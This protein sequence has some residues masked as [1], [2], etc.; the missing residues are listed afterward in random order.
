MITPDDRESTTTSSFCAKSE[1]LFGQQRRDFYNRIGNFGVVEL[2]DWTMYD[3][4]GYF[5]SQCGNF[6]IN[7]AEKSDGKFTYIKHKQLK[8]VCNIMRYF[9]ECN[10]SIKFDAFYPVPKEV[11]RQIIKDYFDSEINRLKYA[12]DTIKSVELMKHSKKDIIEFIN[13]YT[14]APTPDE[15]GFVMCEE[16]ETQNSRLEQQM[17]IISEDNFKLKQQ[18]EEIMKENTELKQQI[19]L[20]SNN[21]DAQLN[22]SPSIEFYAE[23]EELKSKV[24]ELT[25]QLDDKNELLSN[26]INENNQLKEQQRIINHDKAVEQANVGKTPIK[27]VIKSPKDNV[28]DLIREQVNVKNID[29]EIDYLKMNVDE[30]ELSLT[31]QLESLI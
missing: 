21:N 1:K 10:Q 16:L 22:S 4:L 28:M 7:P 14:D 31:K 27:I 18:M 6:T 9:A 15:R 25:Q 20:Q 3:F 29:D 26:V 13:R 11:D 8:I 17:N 23:I 30:N 19:K 12:F 5:R 2:Q 24:A